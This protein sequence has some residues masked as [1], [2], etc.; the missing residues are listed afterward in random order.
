[1]LE[2]APVTDPTGANQGI[3]AYKHS[4]DTWFLAAAEFAKD[5]VEP[6]PILIPYRIGPY[7][8]KIPDSEVKQISVSGYPELENGFQANYVS[9]FLSNQDPL[10]SIE[11]LVG[12]PVTNITNSN[13][14]NMIIG[15]IH[16]TQ[17][18]DGN[19]YAGACQANGVTL[20]VFIVG[21]DNRQDQIFD[22]IE[23]A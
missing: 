15:A 8:M 1:M 11:Q 19:V 12:S 17:P 3:D 22:S 10:M 5:N 23:L 4:G 18:V 16:I 20:M 7:K 9:I 6:Q 2:E 13:G 21:N 14:I